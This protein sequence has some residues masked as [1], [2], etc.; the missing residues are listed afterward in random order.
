[1]KESFNKQLQNLFLLGLM[2]F[3]TGAIF[4]QQ[5]IINGTVTDA[6]GDPI[7]GANVYIEGTTQGTVSDI[8]GNFSLPD[9]TAG[10]VQLSVSFIGYLTETQ[11]VTVG[12]GVSVEANFMLIED[13]QQ[14]SEV[15]VIG[16]GVQKKSD[17]TGAVA[18]V[19]SEDLNKV[20]SQDI[21]QALQGRAAGVY[22]LGNTAAPGANIDITIR[23]ITS[24][25]K[26][27]PLW[28][29][30]G[31][32][33]DPKSVNNA[34]VESVEILKDA[35]AGAI[36]GANAANGVVLITTKKG[37]AGKNTVNFD[38]YYGWQQAYNLVEVADGPGFGRVFTEFEAIQGIDDFF[39]SNTDTLP[40]IDYQKEILRTAPMSSYDLSV[41]GGNENSTYFVGLGYMKQEGIVK[42][43]SYDRLS[44]RINSEHKGNKWLT[45]GENVSFTRQKSEG[46]H[47]WQYFNEYETPI[48]PT[49]TYH[50]FIPVYVNPDGSAATEKNDTTNWSS[51]PL[52]NTVNPVGR[53]E[54]KNQEQQ[55]YLAMG[56]AFIKIHP[57][58]GLTYENR[59][60]G[61]F[62]YTDDVEFTPIYM[63]TPTI[64]NDNSRIYRAASQNKSWLWQHILSYSTTLFDD[65]NVLVMAGFE[66]GYGKYETMSAERM[67]LINE[68]EEMWYF[69]ASLNNEA[70]SQFPDGYA[71]ESSNYSYFGRLNY[72]YKGIV[73]AQGNI[74][75][76]YSSK[77][78]P[79]NRSG[80]FPSFSVG[81]K[82]SEIGA[83]KNN[84]TWLNFGKIRYGWGKVGN[85]AIPDYAYYATIA[86]A[87]VYMYSFNNDPA[88]STGAASNKLA[89]PQIAWEGVVTSNIGIDIGLLSNR[90]FLTADYFVRRNDGMLMEKEAPYYQGY[91]VGASSVTQ[92]GGAS[93]PIMNIGEL[94][95]SGI[96]I[97]ASWKDNVG[98]F[99]YGI[100]VNFT[101][102][103]TEAVSL[104][105][106]LNLGQTKGVGGYLTRTQ[107]G[108]PIGEYYGYQTDGLFTMDDIQ[109]DAN[110][111]PVL[112]SRGQY[113]VVNQPYIINDVGEIEY[114]QPHAQPGDFCFVDA[115]GD[116][117]LT[118]DDYVP[119]GNPNPKYL[120]GLTLDFEYGWFDLS[121]FWQGV[122]GNKLF[123]SQKYYLYGFDGQYNVAADYED[124]HWRD[125]ILDSEGNVLF[126]ENHNATYPRIDPTNA[127]ENFSS[128]SDFY[129]EDGSYLR[130][131]NLQLGMT[132]PK[133]I[134]LKA[135]IERCRIYI[136]GTNL[137]TFTKYTGFDPEIGSNKDPNASS[138]RESILV[139]G[140][141]KG[142]YPP[143][144]M[145]SVGIN[146]TF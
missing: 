139:R 3:C 105:D 111:D 73:L 15:V 120:L 58:K 106:T 76:D 85:N 9:I 115:N 12:D 128:M 89:N 41:S 4:A 29:V 34:D 98:K 52:G 135:G 82:F 92:E 101:Y 141:D 107:P 143:A 71:N 124:N 61:S 125:E 51:S 86:T 26:T 78:G 116:G 68:S 1:M 27:N 146:L 70:V 42:R 10:S 93:N 30:D 75:K 7:I 46:F 49:V 19:S 84:L 6:N 63:L 103:K 18:S 20:P 90:F 47:E 102:L 110:G 38:T 96:E 81:L 44:L 65:H 13:L 117:E 144:R 131:K 25:N 31:V 37:K 17:L 55:T 33:A 22:A 40:T 11:T 132:L 123:N 59:I 62:K 72:D 126:V 36:Y 108:E 54:L 83:I 8:D 114:A 127:N 136:S 53:V 113:I 140:L 87:P 80:V 74:R 138:N 112:T 24:I 119:I 79:K 88:T 104:P 16:Y 50:P 64:K 100:N 121:M 60:T 14:L 142:T 134:S 56:T 21:S 133:E 5:G 66:A 77:F 43:T 137:L 109:R 35:S 39:F 2:I 129:M 45:I 67:D 95:N 32:P 69:R 23:G 97:T 118:L 57:L 122:F 145:Y 94:K 91:Y 99:G 130:L 28:I 48:L